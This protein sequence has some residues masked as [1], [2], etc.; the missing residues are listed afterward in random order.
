MAPGDNDPAD[1]PAQGAADL[2][3]DLLKERGV[4][5]AGGTGV[6]TAPEGAPELGRVTSAPFSEVL[7]HTM[8]TSDNNSAEMLL[9]EIAVQ[10]GRPGTSQ[11]GLDVIVSTLGEWGLPIEGVVPTDG[12]GLDIESKETCAVL[13]GA[14]DRA[15]VN[16]V[17]TSS[18]PLLGREGTLATFLTDHPLAGVARA[19]TGSLGE[20][21]ERTDVKAL[22][23]IVPVDGMSGGGLVFSMVLNGGTVREESTFVPLWDELFDALATYPAG[24]AAADLAPLSP[25]GG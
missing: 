22:S 15:G 18:L 20:D 8:A 14:L 11:D 12:S 9:K 5:I 6:G 21:A 2:F 13:T 17:L 19:K 10:S 1:V 24:P 7:G 25:R 16:S 4:T 23:G 3:A